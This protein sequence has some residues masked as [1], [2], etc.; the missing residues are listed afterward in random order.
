MIC[1]TEII[2][3]IVIFCMNTKLYKLVLKSSRLLKETMH[4][5]FNIHKYYIVSKINNY[6]AHISFC[7]LLTG[8]VI[9]FIISEHF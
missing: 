2:L 1:F 9:Y 3:N 7:M 4:F 6:A 5:T 8:T